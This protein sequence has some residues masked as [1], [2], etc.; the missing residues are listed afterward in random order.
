MEG[1][2][3]DVEKKSPHRGARHGMSRREFLGIAGAGAVLGFGAL[4]GLIARKALAQ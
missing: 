3:K 2:S 1:A 4:D